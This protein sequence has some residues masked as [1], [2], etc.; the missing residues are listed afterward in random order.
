L[1]H[2]T[3]TFLQTAL[4]GAAVW[5]WHQEHYALLAAIWLT[6][7][8]VAHNKLVAFHEAAHG[9]LQPIRWLNELVGQ[10]LGCIT[11]VP[12]T[13]YRMVHAQHHAYLGTVRDV[14]FW[15][16]VDPDVSRPWRVLAVCAELL[17]AYVYDPLIFLHGVWVLH[18]APAAQRRRAWREYAA[19]ACAWCTLAV[20][21]TWRGWWPEFCVAFLIP[22]Y[23][24]AFLNA[25][26]RLVE[27][28]GLLGSTI[29]TKTR[30]IL[31]AR[32]ADR[33]MSAAA[34]R[35]NYHTVHHR[36]ARVPY[37]YLAEATGLLY[38]H[39]LDRLPVFPSYWRAL[40]DTLPHLANPRI[41]AQWRTAAAS[42]QLANSNTPTFDL[43][44]STSDFQP[45]SSVDAPE[46]VLHNGPR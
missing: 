14:E 2:G 11:L 44:S 27:H 8:I 26:R 7:I 22:S 41:G 25:V 32:I 20:V 37:Y 40:L 15:P 39:E 31:P 13:A 21:L 45:L 28:L 9:L 35:V 4:W 1:L 29:E 30:T 43:Q 3:L 23:I 46:P 16:F 5:A 24:A 10:I 18:T 33:A 34:L 38:A 12:L 42:M 17:C 6:S 36:Y 19:C